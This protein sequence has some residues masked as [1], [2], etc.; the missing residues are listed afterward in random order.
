M[1]HSKAKKPFVAE[2]LRNQQGKTGGQRLPAGL[3]DDAAQARHD[4]MLAALAEVRNLVLQMAHTATS[5][6]PAPAVDPTKL[7]GELEALRDSIVNTKREIAAVR[8]PSSSSDRLVVATDELDAVVAATE[9]ATHTILEAAETVDDMADR[10]KQ[11]SKDEFIGRI[12]DEMREVIIKIFEACN[13]Q[14]I[15]GQRITKVVNTVK[16]IEEHVDAMIAI[17]GKDAFAEIAPPLPD[18]PVEA[19]KALL[20]GPQLSNAAVSQDDIDKLF[21]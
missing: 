20:S 14:D 8:H 19:D 6:I 11:A 4:E 13:F 5:A 21:G 16:F 3:S 18:M 17:W 7:R 10:I 15:T 1:A 2:M 9:Q 12:A